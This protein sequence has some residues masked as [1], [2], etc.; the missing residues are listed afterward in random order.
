M[1]AEIEQ[2]KVQ[3]ELV[4]HSLGK[5]PDNSELITLKDE[6]EELIKLSDS[7][8][9][10]SDIVPSD[11]TTETTEGRNEKEPSDQQP[12]KL[13]NA[14]P[15]DLLMARWLSGDKAYYPAKVIA[16][17]GAREWKKYTVKFID[18]PNTETVPIDCVKLLPESKK[19]NIEITQPRNL[20]L[21]PPPPPPSKPVNMPPPPPP[22]SSA[23]P[24]APY[25]TSNVASY[26]QKMQK[27][28]KPKA[29]LEAS[30]NSWKQF[31]AR[32]VKAGRV[33][34]RKKIGET[35]IFRSPEGLNGRVG[36]MGSGRGTTK[37]A[38]REKHIYKASDDDY[39]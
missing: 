24:S 28:L 37:S 7:L 38:A 16:V 14:K 27:H 12:G 13:L 8:A 31:A 33:G 18:Y 39:E 19:R 32:G 23:Q 26:T 35:S 34:K 20:A 29:A 17:S 10:A 25:T 5:D 9:K 11:E 4:K 1:D 36:F 2:Y 3:L 22:P 21:P 6:L 15:G 30:Q